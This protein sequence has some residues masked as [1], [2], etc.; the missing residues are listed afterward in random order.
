MNFE[1]FNSFVERIGDDPSILFK[2]WIAGEKGVIF[3]TFCHFG[4]VRRRKPFCYDTKKDTYPDIWCGYQVDKIK[5]IYTK[6]M[7]QL[8]PEHE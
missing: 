3:L 1:I 8:C 2:A 5:G 7:S 6:G 4:F